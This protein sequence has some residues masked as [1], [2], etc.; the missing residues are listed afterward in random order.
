MQNENLSAIKII[1]KLIRIGGECGL[2]FHSNS[3]IFIRFPI[4]R[5]ESLDEPKTL[6]GHTCLILS[7]NPDLPLLPFF[8][9]R[10]QV[11]KVIIGTLRWR[12]PYLLSITYLVLLTL[13]AK[14]QYRFSTLPV[15]IRLVNVFNTLCCTCTALLLV[16]VN[17]S[18]SGSRRI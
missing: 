17:F 16:S 9:D 1:L 5:I 7:P 10:L 15:V 18:P 2:I 11:C 3:R 14:S 8:F 4:F 13:F 12:E 6:E